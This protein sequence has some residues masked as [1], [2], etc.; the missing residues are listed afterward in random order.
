MNTMQTK[1]TTMM[2]IADFAENMT[3]KMKNALKPN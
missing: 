1:S 3:A 2:K